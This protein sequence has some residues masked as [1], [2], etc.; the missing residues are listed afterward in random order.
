MPATM[1]KTETELHEQ[2]ARAPATTFGF[3]PRIGEGHFSDRYFNRA[4]A[5]LAHGG[6]DPTVTVQVFAKKPGV[7]AGT[8]EAIRML[9]AFLTEGYTPDD[10]VVEA[11]PE[12]SQMNREVSWEPVM[13]IHGPYRAFGHLETPLLG[14]LARRSLVATNT[15]AAVEAARGKPII[16]MAPRHEDWRLQQV[17]GWAALVGG[18]AAVSSDAAAEWAGTRG[19]GTMPHALIAAKHGDT[20]AATRSFARYVTDREPGV[21]IVS[22]VDYD[23]DVIGT[24]LAVAREVEAE[25]GPGALQAVRVDTS[26][27]II[28]RALLEDPKVFG[29]EK[30]TGVT[31]T[32]VRKLRSAL[33]EAGFT[34][35]GIIASGG[36]TPAKIEAFEEAGVPVNGYGVGSSLLGHNNGAGGLHSGLD[37]TADVVEVDGIPEAK[38]GRHYTENPRLERV[39]W[40]GIR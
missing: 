31:P 28:D 17:D 38:V 19:V 3:D 10:I 22:L 9:E 6:E 21:D 30:A 29:R 7:V 25:F 15:R 24:S 4:V 36:F 35:V 34:H 8:P 13:H 20:V 11:L 33:D 2:L 37:F 14:V 18:A 27:R 32:L 23:N 1:T 16:Y 12:G 5:T 40:E 26:E 39:D